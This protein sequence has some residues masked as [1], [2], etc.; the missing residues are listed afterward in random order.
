MILGYTQMLLEGIQDQEKEPEDAES[1]GPADTEMNAHILER[2]LCNTLTVHS[3]VANYLDLSKIEAGQL[4][5]AKH[6]VQLNTILE[7]VS[8][9]YETAAR[10]ANVQ[11]SLHLQDGKGGQNEMDE[12]DEMDE[13]P[14]IT[15]DALALERV[16]A[17]LVSNALKF[18]PEGG[19]VT[20]STTQ[21]DGSVV[22]AIT[23]TG[24]GMNPEEIPS[25]FEKYRRAKKDH[26]KEGIG[27][28]LF[29]V[30]TLVN[31]HNGRIQVESTP[32]RGSCFQLFFPSN[33]RL[34]GQNKQVA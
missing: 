18:T 8:T 10:N 9:K 15:G 33:E 17:N 1:E 34:C 21:H 26:S 11:L 29:I 13:L 12:M 24:S 30:K 2:I 5:I 22:A 7:Q 14:M 16:F 20:L 28:G 4:S 31:Q 3:L 6:P 27:L 25:L 32:G 19:Q 23:D